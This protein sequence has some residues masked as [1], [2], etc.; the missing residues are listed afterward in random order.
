MLCMHR[1]RDFFCNLE[2]LYAAS[3][4][5]CMPAQRCATALV[6]ASRCATVLSRHL[7]TVCMRTS[8]FIERVAAAGFVG[9]PAACCVRQSSICFPQ[10]PLLGGGI[11]FVSGCF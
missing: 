8:L 7:C 2:L 10:G 5:A 1:G 11:K 3:S 9:M 4:E 6:S